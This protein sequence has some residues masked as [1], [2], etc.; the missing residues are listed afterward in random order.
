M[1]TYPP[2]PK[3]TAA[4]SGSRPFWSVMIPTYNRAA[5][6]GKPLA[7]VMSQDPGPD[8]M[9]IEVVD[10]ASTEGDTEAVV[11]RIGNGRISLFRQPRNLG[12]TANWNSC[13]DRARGE[14]V[15]ILHSD[16]YVLP[17]FYERLRAQL[18]R[19][20]EP[21]AAFCR[22]LYVDEDGRELGRSELES[23]TPGI[24]DGFIGK[25]GIS[26]RIQ[27]AS[28]VVRRAVYE[29]LGGFRTA[30]RYIPDWD[31]WIRIAAHFPIWYE[32]SV[33]A[34]FRI[35]PNSMTSELVKSG[36][37]IREERLCIRLVRPLLPADRAEAIS[38][39]ACE[40]A[41]LRALQAASNL[42]LIGEWGGASRQV[43]GGL[44]CSA[45]PRVMEKLFSSLVQMV[46]WGTRR[47]LCAVKRQFAAD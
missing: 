42:I 33:L 39:Q 38:R 30:L 21:G 37:T 2:A 15:H 46:R 9:Q 12:G 28:I 41:A 25:L 1:Q 45:S 26:Q 10:D 19:T 32:P 22:H 24:L 3:I 44:A 6:I 36:E 27:F 17:G 8:D 35:H 5:Y 20:E 13:I 47:T 18:E 34:A 43:L 7:S 14:W 40:L 29:K 23:A 16:D 31:M 11:Q 4:G